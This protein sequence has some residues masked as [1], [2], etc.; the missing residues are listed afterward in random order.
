MIFSF[1]WFL[2]ICLRFDTIADIIVERAVYDYCSF[3]TFCAL[4]TIDIAHSLLL[5]SFMIYWNDWASGW[6]N[7]KVEYH[8]P[9]VNSKKIV[10]QKWLWVIARPD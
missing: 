6:T 8:V 5:K 10:L 7:F 4:S 1:D 2:R 9:S 3:E